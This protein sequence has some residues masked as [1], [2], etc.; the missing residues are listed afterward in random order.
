MPTYCEQCGARVFLF[1]GR[2]FA[3]ARD[4][5]CTDGNVY[6]QPSELELAYLRREELKGKVADVK[7]SLHEA[8]QALAEAQ[9]EYD[10]AKAEFCEELDSQ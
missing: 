4:E 2:W 10:R 3:D 9:A 6:H 7:A 5:R 8:W 1:L